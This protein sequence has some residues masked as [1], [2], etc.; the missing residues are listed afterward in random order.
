MDEEI[1]LALSR[2]EARTMRSLSGPEASND[3]NSVNSGFGKD[4]RSSP[5]TSVGS[6]AIALDAASRG[7]SQLLRKEAALML[8]RK[9]RSMHSQNI[10]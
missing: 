6:N 1:Y 7:A 3:S 5:G 10:M 2:L 4:P 9:K 8:R